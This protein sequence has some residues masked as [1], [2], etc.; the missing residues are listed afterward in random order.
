MRSIA[1]GCWA[2]TLLLVLTACSSAADPAPDAT[3]SPRKFAAGPWIPGFVADMSEA[4]E[5]GQLLVPSVGGTRHA[6]GLIAKYHVGGFVYDTAETRSPEQ[7]ARL[8]NTLQDA[9]DLP[10]LIGLGAEK[11]GSYFTPLPD[12]Q[13]IAADSVPSDARAVARVAD[14]EGHAVGVTPGYGPVTGDGSLHLA[15]GRKLR[16]D[17]VVRAVQDG[18]DQLID[19]PDLPR[20]YKAVL[21]AVQKGKISQRRLDEAVTRILRLKAAR[22]LFGDTPAD[23]GKADRIVGSAANRAVVRTVAEHSI[24]LVRNDPPDGRSRPLL[25][26]GSAQVY[27]TGPA[28]GRVAAAL[29]K[30]GLHIAKSARKADAAVLTTQDAKHDIGSRVKSLDRSAPVIVIALGSPDDLAGA[31][32][33]TAAV[34]AYGDDPLSLAATAGVLTGTV[35]PAGR[36]PV[37]VS[38]AYPKGHGLSLPT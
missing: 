33:A 25:P 30:V 34:A 21:K 4:A 31:R 14:A 18:A 6:L 9:S 19:P 20:A 12:D 23:P 13:A 7:T 29:R 37:E 2:G 5:V 38:H 17:G 22:G 11:A 15:R 26:L 24:T 16:G 3:P 28:A 10:L 35:R 8:S 36:L 1:H 32:A 27:V